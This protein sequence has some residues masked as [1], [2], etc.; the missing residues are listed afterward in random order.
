MSLERAAGIYRRSKIHWRRPVI[1]NGFPPRNPK[2]ERVARVVRVRSRGAKNDLQ[3][4]A[5]EREAAVVECRIKLRN[6]DRGPKAPA[7]RY[8][9]NVNVAR[10]KS[11]WPVT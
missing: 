11:A 6:V 4:V 2:I 7:G 8:I 9:A 1:E 3:T 10:T 5:A